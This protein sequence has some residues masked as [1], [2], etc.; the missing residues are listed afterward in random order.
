[1]S[2]KSVILTIYHRYKPSE[3]IDFVLCFI[4]PVGMT[5]VDV[6][7]NERARVKNCDA[8]P[9]PNIYSFI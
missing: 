3:F 8:P 4:V 7:R 5:P 2:T 1:M 6:T 9:P